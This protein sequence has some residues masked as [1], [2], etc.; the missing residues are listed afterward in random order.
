MHPP[1]DLERYPL[2]DRQSQ[3]YVDLVERCRAD[4]ARDGMFNLEGFMH[5]DAI[6]ETVDAVA[7]RLTPVEAFVH[8]RRHNIYFKKIADLPEDHPAL[9]EVETKNLTL[10]ADQCEG[11]PVDAV[12]SWQPLADFLADT[13]EQEALYP[14]PDP[15]ARFNVMGYPEGW[16]LNWHFDRSHFTTTL[17]LQAPD[18]GGDFVY[19]S[20]LRS[21]TDPNYD[22]VAHLLE[23]KDPNVKSFT[24]SAGTLNVFKGKNT[25]HR[26]TPVIGDTPRIVAVLTYYDRPGVNFTPE[27]RIG[28]YGRAE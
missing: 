13:M 23:G 1:I 5:E 6:K 4:L 16:G 19:R 9:R 15:L 28:F 12:Y 17:L 25:A 8:A 21:D 27:E 7:S 3:R 11:L 18:A 20:D 10:C 14:M 26:V 22:G 2:H 24:A